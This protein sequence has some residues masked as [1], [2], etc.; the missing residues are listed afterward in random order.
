MRGI[1]AQRRAYWLVPFV[2]TL[3][4]ESLL[5]FEKVVTM[6]SK[7]CCLDTKFCQSVVGS[8]KF[9][10]C[11]FTEA[12]TCIVIWMWTKTKSSNRLLAPGAQ[13]VVFAGRACKQRTAR[14]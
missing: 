9:K 3:I 10:A 5:V 12:W 1:Q 6:P 4:P 8:D 2:A 13:A 11:G 14:I 7:K